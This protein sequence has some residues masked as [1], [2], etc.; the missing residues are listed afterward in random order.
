MIN[1]DKEEAILSALNEAS[2]RQLS[3]VQDHHW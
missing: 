3:I 2:V 1:Q